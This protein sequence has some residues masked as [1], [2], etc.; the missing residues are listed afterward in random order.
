MTP[1]IRLISPALS[2]PLYVPPR[3]EMGGRGVNGLSLPEQRQVI[4]ATPNV[5]LDLQCNYTQPRKIISDISS[6]F[7]CCLTQN[8][9]L[10]FFLWPWRILF[11]WPF[12]SNR[13]CQYIF[14]VA[15]LLH[16]QPLSE[17]LLKCRAFCRISQTTYPYHN[18]PGFQ[19][20]AF[21][22]SWKFGRNCNVY[23]NIQN[24]WLSRKATV[25]QITGFVVFF[26]LKLRGLT[27]HG[28][29][30]KTIPTFLGLH[31]LNKHN[32]V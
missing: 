5:S 27:N 7:K 28:Q 3:E 22:C 17:T 30:R 11:S 31:A 24:T 19:I 1:K 32:F 6:K 2:S 4:E 14:K 13:T 21:F 8:K 23:S 10:C 18:L 20:M 26:G 15:M 12:P 9:I 16:W 29:F 25:R